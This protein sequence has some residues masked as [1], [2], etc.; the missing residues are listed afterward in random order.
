MLLLSELV[1]LIG[2]SMLL[3]FASLKAC[4]FFH[5]TFLL[6]VC[7]VS[8]P[9]QGLGVLVG[10]DVTFATIKECN[11]HIAPHLVIHGSSLWLF[12]D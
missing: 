9:S 6:S 11:L 7:Y 1:C 5:N 8:A 10:A 2:E 12:C 4:L 3:R